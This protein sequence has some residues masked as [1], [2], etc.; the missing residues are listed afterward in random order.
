[1]KEV[2]ITYIITD[3]NDKEIVVIGKAGENLLDIAHDNK[4]E[5]QHNCGGV[6]GCSTCQVYIEGGQD[7]LGEISDAEEDRIDLAENPKLNSRLACQCEIDANTTDL[8]V[9]IPKQDFLGH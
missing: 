2:K 9:R 3:E 6:C 5:L 7:S 1:M 8:K 4:I